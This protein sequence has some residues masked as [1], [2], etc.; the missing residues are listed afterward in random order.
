MS[1]AQLCLPGENLRI[2]VPPPPAQRPEDFHRVAP[3]SQAPADSWIN[4]NVA[5]FCT[6]RQKISAIYIAAGL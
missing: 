4:T 5:I 3:I 6:S 2:A 1:F